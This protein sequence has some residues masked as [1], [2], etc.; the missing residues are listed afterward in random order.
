MNL[1]GYAPKLPESGWETHSAPDVRQP[2]E[3]LAVAIAGKLAMR[4]LRA[5]FDV[6]RS[7][8]DLDLSRIMKPDCVTFIAFL[9]FAESIARLDL[10]IR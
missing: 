10:R 7:G 6:S 4:P 8:K 3:K 5:A 1:I 2:E 9:C